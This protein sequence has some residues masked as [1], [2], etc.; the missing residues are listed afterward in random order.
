MKRFLSL[1]LSVTLIIGVLAACS[2]K[3]TGSKEGGKSKVE[4]WTISLQPTFNDYFNDLIAKYEEKN[5]KVKIVW[6]DY[7]Y[8]AIQNKLLTS[9]ASG[10]AP[11]VV[12]LNTEFANQMGTKDALVDLN[13]E[14][15]QEQKDAYFKGIYASTEIDGK[16][17]ALPWYTGLPVLFINKELVEKAG[18]DPNNPPKTKEELNQWGKTIKEKTGA[19]GYVFTMEARSILEEGNKLL[20]DDY[21]KAAFNNDDV[22][23]SIKENVQLMKDGVIPKDILDYDKQIQFFGSEQVAMILSSSPFINKIKSASPDVYKKMIAVPSPVGK[24]DIRFSNTMNVVVPA[25]TKHKKEAVDFAAYVTNAENQ[26]AFS[27]AASTLPSTVDSAKDAF[28][29]KNDGTLEGQALTVSAASLDKATDFYLGIANASDV[30]GSI[31]KHLQN[32]YLNNA[33]IDKELSAAEKEVNDI[34][35]K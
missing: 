19:Y 22:K 9:I 18:L 5:P 23:A 25:K 12:N 27:K 21:S 30:N 20:T 11:G 14:L 28:F 31:N 33:D 1:F 15:T 35:K 7:P 29:S 17:N 8:D 32:I 16:A 34:L 4:F 26:L 13:K 6:K 2:S 3:E 10:E 24:A